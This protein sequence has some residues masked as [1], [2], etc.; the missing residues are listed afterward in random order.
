[1]Y[2]AKCPNCKSNISMF[3]KIE[4]GSITCKKCACKYKG[5]YEVAWQKWIIEYGVT[6]FVPVISVSLLYFKVI[7][8]WGL[9]A[10]LIPTLFFSF[11]VIPKWRKYI[12]VDEDE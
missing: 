1:M 3:A 10:I 5:V 7:N 9:L 12:L 8:N 6:F 2:D 11:L 4:N